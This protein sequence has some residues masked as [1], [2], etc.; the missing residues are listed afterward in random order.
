MYIICFTSG[1]AGDLVTATIDSKNALI[2]NNGKV[3]LTHKRNTLKHTVLPEPQSFLESIFKEYK[4]ISSHQHIISDYTTISIGVRDDKLYT[5][6]AERFNKIY[7]SKSMPKPF[8]DIDTTALA[9]ILKNMNNTMIANT[10]HL[11]YFDDIIEGKLIEKLQEFV[12]TELNQDLYNK[13]LMYWGN[14]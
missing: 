12:P 1:L 14:R 2:S 3:L 11:L 8:G 9:K 5:I 10:D 6:A 4:S 13:W 7:S